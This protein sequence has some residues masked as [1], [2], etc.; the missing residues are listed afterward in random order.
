MLHWCGILLSLRCAVLYYFKAKSRL[1]SFAYLLSG[2]FFAFLT[3]LLLLVHP[4]S[5]D[6]APLMILSLFFGISLL[7]SLYPLFPN[8]PFSTFFKTL[9]SLTF[10][11]LSL[12]ALSTHGFIKLT[13]EK[14]LVTL[15]LTGKKTKKWVEWKPPQGPLENA[16]LD[17]NE[18]LVETREGKLL[19]KYALYGD[20]VALRIKLIRLSRLLNF[21][22]ISN[23]CHIEAIHNGYSS[24]QSHNHYPHIG[25]PLKSPHPL[26]STLWSYLFYKESHWIGVDAATLESE[27]I[28]LFTEN[29]KPVASTFNLVLK[30][31]KITLKK[32]LEPRAKD[33]SSKPRCPG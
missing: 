8:F 31:G 30:D 26:F 21:F 16:W 28:P 18:I 24:M 3:L 23:T 20:F 6:P 12:F 10:I 33:D 4:L 1:E 25:Y 22:G 32:A 17:T 27:Y 13:E 14:T 9:C 15:I 5:I 2:L 11:L 19:G 7:F 29:K